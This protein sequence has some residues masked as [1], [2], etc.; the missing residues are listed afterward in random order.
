MQKIIEMSEQA[1]DKYFG[2]VGA[3]K[4]LLVGGKSLDALAVGDYFN[5]LASRTG[6]EVVRFSDFK[7]NPD[8]TSVLAGVKLYKEKGCDMVAAVGGGSAMDTAKCIKMY[9]TMDE[10]KEYI[11]QKIVPNDIE[12]LVVPTTAGTGSEATRYAIIYYNGNKVSVTDNSCIPTAVVFDPDALKTLPDYQ[13]KATMMDALCHAVESYW[14]VHSTEESKAYAAEAIELIFD[15]MEEY[16]ANTEKGNADMLKAANIAGKA[17]NITATTA[18]HAMCYKL[19]TGYGLAH[20]HAAALCVNALF[21]YMVKNTDKCTDARGQEYFSGMMD[22]LADIICG[23]NPLAAAER[24]DT[25]IKDLGLQ[26]PIAHEGDIEKLTGS[27][28]IERLKNHPV[29]LDEETIS[30]LYGSIVVME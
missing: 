4:I 20:G 29:K 7:P 14:S 18:G 23:A 2:E 26:R 25:L 21:P 9:V 13:R 6:I 10:S 30:E 17:I 24:F 12:F 8:Y 5:N 28:N 11:E 27:V 22:E 1:L 3:K 19:T 16:L 15:S